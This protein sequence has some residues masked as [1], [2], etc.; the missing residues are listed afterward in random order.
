MIADV[1][2]LLAQ[3]GTITAAQVRDHFNTSRR[4]ALAFLEHLDVIGVT[5]REGD[6]RRL[7]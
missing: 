4:Y 7:K 2:S 6:V 1:H 3:N 5:L